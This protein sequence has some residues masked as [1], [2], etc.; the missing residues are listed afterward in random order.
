MELMMCQTINSLGMY[1]T[2]EAE[3]CEHCM[4][5]ARADG[6]AYELKRIQEDPST[7]LF[8]LPLDYIRR[9]ISEDKQRG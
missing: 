9:L 3:F 5:Q 7:Q 2:G 6:I 8:G 1:C 4:S